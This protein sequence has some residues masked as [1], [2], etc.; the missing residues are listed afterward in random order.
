MKPHLKIEDLSVQIFADGAD[1]QKIAQLARNSLIRGFTTN[2]SLMRKEGVTVY[3]AGDRSVSLEVFADE[4]AEMERQARILASWGKSVYVKLPVTNTKGESTAGV[5][6]RLCQSGIKVNITA[7][8]TLDQVRDVTGALL[9]GAP[10]FV[11]VF[12][13]RIADTGRD[14]MPLMAAAAE[15]VHSSSTTQLIWASAREFLNVIQAD[16][17]GCDIIT[18][19]PK[20]LERIPFMEKDLHQ[21]S[22]DTVAEFYRD[23][24]ASGLYI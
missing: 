15:M 8:F 6:R 11:S 20:F 10:S 1:R 7:L 12:A 2:P 22:L 18:I 19:T 3:V 13:G 4:P 14:P 9:N 16:A 24:Y 21:Y 5:A 23:A 17:V